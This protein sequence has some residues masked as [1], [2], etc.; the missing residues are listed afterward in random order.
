MRPGENNFSFPLGERGGKGGVP[1]ALRF[2]I[3]ARRRTDQRGRRARGSSLTEA[4]IKTEV[5]F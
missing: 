1:C 5:M 2:F 3:S 4:I